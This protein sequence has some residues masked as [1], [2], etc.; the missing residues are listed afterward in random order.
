MWVQVDQA[1]ARDSACYGVQ[2]SLAVVLWLLVAAGLFGVWRSVIP[3]VH[4]LTREMPE[5]SYHVG[6][7]SLLCLRF[8]L[9]AWLVQVAFGGLSGAPG[10]PRQATW[11][12]LALFVVHGALVALFIVLR[13]DDA[14]MLRRVLPELTATLA[15]AVATLVWL[16]VSRRVNATYR[17]RLRRREAAREPEATEPP[18]GRTTIYG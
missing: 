12:I 7:T 15:L 2:G 10:F 1:R 11:S 13:K 17:H 18:L 9:S 5:S 4:L 16:Q 14:I 6:L 8:A 3:L